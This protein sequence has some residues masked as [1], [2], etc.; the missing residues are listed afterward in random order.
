MLFKIS[1]L[2]TWKAGLFKIIQVYPEKSEF[3]VLFE[4]IVDELLETLN[5]SFSTIDLLLSGK[6]REIQR[7]TKL[8]NWIHT[9]IQT[10]TDFFPSNAFEEFDFSQYSGSECKYE[11]S[12]K[13]LAGETFLKYLILEMENMKYNTLKGEY[14]IS[15]ILDLYRVIRLL[16][17]FSEK[18]NLKYFYFYLEFQ[19][20]F[21]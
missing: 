2:S 5:K 20:T 8:A 21:L 18:H 10:Y 14:E 1:N 12:I 16:Y 7:L 3:R 15:E 19:S 11:L 17:S 9:S 4:E 6:Q 13:K